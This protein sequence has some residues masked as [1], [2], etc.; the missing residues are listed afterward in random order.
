MARS[1]RSSC[2]MSGRATARARLGHAAEARRWLDNFAA[3]APR[4]DAGPFGFLN[5]LEVVVLRRE[6]EAVVLLDPG[7]PAEPFIP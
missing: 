5:D 1:R 4:P 7:I 3:R 6:A 2:P